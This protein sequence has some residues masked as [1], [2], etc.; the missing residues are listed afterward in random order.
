MKEKHTVKSN[1]KSIF[2]LIELLVVI[3]IIAILAGMLLPALSRARDTAKAISCKSNIKQINVAL[4]FYL[5]DSKEFFPGASAQGNYQNWNWNRLLVDYWKYITWKVMLDPSMTYS[6]QK[7]EPTV[8][9]LQK[10][11]YFAYTS[12]GYNYMILGYK[13]AEAYINPRP[14]AG[15]ANARLKEIRHPSK[16]YVFMDAKTEGLQTGNC[17]VTCR[18]IAGAG[19]PD[20][21]RHKGNVATGNGDGSVTQVNVRIAAL[22]Y[23]SGMGSWDGYKSGDPNT[24]PFRRYIRWDGGRFDD[25]HSERP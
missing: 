23:D 5:T 22:P 10:G 16:L 7:V 8:E 13:N 12:Y 11:D 3:A 4:S 2:T 15:T 14:P 18:A 25:P 1:E 19:M 24:K 20:A 6:G 9:K 21:Y 17:M